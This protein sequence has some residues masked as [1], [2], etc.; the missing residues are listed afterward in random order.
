MG[1]SSSIGTVP[2][3]VIIGLVVYGLV[4][5][6]SGSVGSV[7]LAAVLVVVVFAIAGGQ[8]KNKSKATSQAT[9][10]KKRDETGPSPA[11]QN[12]KDPA[13]G[14][15]ISVEEG[16]YAISRRSG[17][18][19]NC[20]FHRKGEQVAIHGFTIDGLVYIGTRGRLA[21]GEPAIIDP[22][23][24]ATRSALA[25]PLGYWPDYGALTPGQRGQYLGWLAGGRGHTDELGYVFLFFYGLERYVYRDAAQ[26]SDEVRDSTLNHIVEEVVRLRQVFA[27]NRSFD[28]YSSNLLDAI[29]VSFWPERIDERKKG[30]PTRTPVAASYAIIRQAN[31]AGEQPLDAD[32]ALQWVLGYGSVSRTKAVRDNYS[33]IRAMFRH[34]YE[35]ATSGG[36]IIP[37]CKRRAGQLNFPH[38]AQGLDDVASHTFAASW[39]SPLELKRPLAQL[40]AIFANVMPSVR[41]LSKALATKQLLE[42]LSAWP[43]DAPMDTSPQLSSIVSSLQSFLAK[44]ESLTATEMGRLFQ[45]PQDAKFTATQCRKIASALKTCGYAL[46]PDPLFSPATLKPDDA[47]CIYRGTR[48]AALS[49]EAERV[50][51]AIRLGSI[52]AL[53]DGELHDHEVATL[54]KR[55][56]SHAN[57]AERQYLHK[58]VDWNLTQSPG[59]A[60][61]KKQIDQLKGDERHE[62]ADMLVEVAQADGALPKAEIRELEKLF[63]R[64]GLET[65]GVTEKLHGA[66][67]SQGPGSVAAVKPVS[68][69]TSSSGVDIDM[70]ALQA[71]ANATR[72]VQSVLSKIFEEEEPE[73]PS[74][75]DI[76]HARPA[77]DAWHEGHLDNHH[78]AL[79]AWL[80]TGDEWSMEEV[81]RK[82]AELGL[83]PEGALTT[84]NEA[85]FE[86]LGD[87][88]IEMGDPVEIYRDVLPV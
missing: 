17:Q 30:L 52:L 67:V 53:A 18:V 38:A 22:T 72:E 78:D 85:A 69:R 33:L 59:A 56:E 64:L 50:A 82:C 66:A 3:L 70:D 16:D 10:S 61:L 48:L 55:V 44:R 71:H 28:G 11:A 31:E 40:E 84:I 34:A 81:A 2:G 54:R 58:Y 80:L 65:A 73:A 41:K 49:P 8:S 6:L 83:M 47:L 68:S 35:G 9:N 43:I 46:V 13:M 25:D 57:A 20:V 79:A 77:S 39:F 74:T 87:S 32:W 26:D 37:S 24:P 7:I 42:I 4:G 88:L 60:G 62:L 19:A 75:S 23:L 51:T 86:T 45:L 63:S 36:L 1:K 21:Y 29:Y 27:D 12:S 5:F 76:E 14:L 15:R